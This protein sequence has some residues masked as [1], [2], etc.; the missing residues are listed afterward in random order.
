MIMNVMKC[1]EDILLSGTRLE[2]FQFL[3][4]VGHVFVSISKPAHYYH[5]FNI[6]LRRYVGHSERESTDEEGAVVPHCKAG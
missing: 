4:S 1:F 2:V 5:P 6:D 3:L